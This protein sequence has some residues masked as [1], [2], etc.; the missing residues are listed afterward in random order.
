MTERNPISLGRE[1]EETLR[2]YLRTALPISRNFP[3]LRQQF[4]QALTPGLLVKGPFVEATPDFQKGSS[5]KELVAEG[6]IHPGFDRLDE[7]EKSRPLHRHQAEALRA[8]V[9]GQENVVV[10]TGTGSGKTE[11]FLY[12]ILDALL[13]DPD[14]AKPGVRALLVYPLNALANDQLYKRLVPLFIGRYAGSGIRIGRFTGLTRRNQS[15]AQAEDEVMARDPF[16]RAAPPDGLGWN[17]I[18]DQW[19]LTRDEMLATPP[20]ILITNYAMLEHLLLFPRNAPLFRDARLRFIVLDEVH[21]YAGAQATEV[22]L[23]LRKLRQRLNLKPE[24]ARCI[25]TSASLD[26]GNEAENKILQFA[27]DLFGAPFQRVIRGERRQH[28][29]LLDDST[30]TFSLPAGAWSELGPIIGRIPTEGSAA[31]QAW[32]EAIAAAVLP[33]E[34]K[35]RLTLP[36]A[37]GLGA[38]LA[39]VFGASEQMRSASQILAQSGT[40]RFDELAESLFGAG[41]L[42]AQALAGLVAIGIRARLTPGEF[43]LLPARYHFFVSGIDNVVVKLG[44]A[45]ASDAAEVVD[46]QLGRKFRDDQQHNWYRLLVCRKCG[47]PYLEAFQDSGHLHPTR[48]LAPNATREIFRLGEQTPEVEDEE[49]NESPTANA[50][51]DWWE[52]DPA[53]GQMTSGPGTVRLAHEPLTADPDTGQR[54]LPKCRTCG[55]RAHN[56]TEIITGFHPGDFALSAVAADAL[57]QQLP[58]KPNSWDL[59]GRGRRLL[60]F[61]DDRQDAAFFAPYLQRT[62]EDLLLRWAVMKALGGDGGPMSLN[63]LADETRAPLSVITFLDSNGERITDD[64]EFRNY[65]R[66]RLAAEFCLPTGRRVSLEALG[67]V[68]VSYEESKLSRAAEQFAPCLPEGMRGQASVLLEVLLETVRRN[69]CISRP[70]GVDLRSAFIWGEEFANTNLRVAIEGTGPQNKFAWLA[71]VD[72]NGGRVYHNRRSW[73]LENQLGLQH[74]P[75]LRAAWR[76]LQDADLLRA[77]EGAF[78]LDVTALRFSDGRNQ[79]LHRCRRCGWRQF[80]NF[81]GKCAAFRCNGELELISEEERR[82][83]ERENHYIAQYLR[84]QG[85]AGLIVKEH[86]AAIHNRLREEMER[87][88]KQGKVN[89]LSCST[90]MELG[91][92]IGELEAVVCRNVPPGIQNYQQR[93]GRAGR[94]A[95]AAPVCVTVARNRN[96]DQSVYQ[97]PERYLHRAPRTPF[98]HLAN[99]R[100]LR[101]HQFS[102]LLRGWMSHQQVEFSSPSLLEFFGQTFSEEDQ[103]Q[104]IERVRQFFGCADG[105]AFI[106]EAVALTNQLPVEVRERMAVT[107]NELLGEFLELFGGSQGFCEWYGSRWRYYHERW[108][109]TANDLQKRR[110]NAFWGYQLDQW[111]DQL[112]INH[113]PRMGLIPSYSFPV[114]SVQLEVLQGGRP[115]AHRQPWDE[116]ILLTRDARLG[117]SEYAPGAEVVAAGRVWT[118]YGVGQYPRHFMP[119]QYYRECPTCRHVEIQLAPDDF[120]GACEKCETPVTERPRAFIEPRSFVTSSVESNG[121]D[122]GVSRIKPPPAQEARLLSSA[123]DTEFEANPTGIPMTQWAFQNARRGRMFVVNRGCG[124]GFFRCGCGY[125]VSLRNPIQQPQQLRQATH[126]TP[127]YQ[128]CPGQWSHPVEDLAHIYQTDVLQIRFQQ[129]VPV[130]QDVPLNQRGKWIEGF[131]RT[132]AEAL[133]RAAARLLD[134]E[135]RELAATTRA[136][137]FGYPEVVLYDSV[138]GGAGYCQ[139]AQQRGLKPLLEEAVRLLDC[140]CEDSCRL[141]LRDYDNERFWDDF[142]RK[143]VL[144]WLKKLLGHPPAPNPFSRFHAV[145]LTSADPAATFWAELDN[146]THALVIAPTLFD[147]TRNDAA[148]AEATATAQMQFVKRLVNWMTAGRTLEVALL[149]APSVGDHHAESLAAA[150]WLEPCLEAGHLKLLK[151]P[152]NFDAL[153]WPRLLLNPGK[154]SARCLF[155]RA[156]FTAAFLKQPLTPPLWRGSGLSTAE[157]SKLRADWQP[158]PARLTEPGSKTIVREY[159]PGEL[160][161]FARDFSFCTGRKFALIRIEDPYAMATPDAVT[162][163]KRF[164]ESL[165]SLCGHWPDELKIQARE[166]PEFGGQAAARAALEKQLQTAGAPKLAVTLIPRFG[167]RRRDFHDRRVVF[168]P[169]AKKPHKRVTVLLTGGVD[170]YLEPRFE[171]GVVV[172][173]T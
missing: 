48:D 16:F 120:T 4:E 20:H 38:G 72:P 65:L 104:Y 95:Q 152:P 141:C 53:N 74:E 91:V 108:Q 37:D 60:V 113:L 156:G 102:V 69:R 122:P 146:A 54:L 15:R 85:Y 18:P 111:Q 93:T 39:R 144:A 107:A 121:R 12:P 52:F 154:D 169:D 19:L 28:A 89:V 94:R 101:R 126:R 127:Y 23:L 75:I 47:Q 166:T 160:R 29:L 165:K 137:P 13:K 142:K 32:N 161:D 43:S 46:L 123:E 40:V 77:D 153:N 25:G 109:A 8:I 31:V 81:G 5:L 148:D 45:E 128:P 35:T 157:L 9:V 6:Q 10:A 110:E 147:F 63:T 129:F 83:E 42:G 124:F 61:S 58:E 11:C 139:L 112:L 140:E 88:F 73:F 167:S 92:D 50:P 171:C 99:V 86:T 56:D 68:R 98:V 87:N 106:A 26:P 80:P 125:T 67:L 131:H 138:A 162:N 30:M 164:L 173:Q 168:V 170:R 90:T 22:A 134:I 66:G 76:A 7:R 130:P 62:N 97:E 14:I 44:R 33:Q 119:T 96:Y 118:S 49:D 143:P 36:G 114:N 132:L 3:K 21:T 78:V 70:R 1:L 149:T 55:G 155:T 27:S 158:L 145:E 103:R 172:H 159:Q 2:R 64:D 59:P 117:I 82:A 41:E 136:L 163:L 100:L 71:S 34:T 135:T 17:R 133:R 116:D 150:K 105:Q 51:T 24:D 84:A 115:S 79:P 57:Y 151:L